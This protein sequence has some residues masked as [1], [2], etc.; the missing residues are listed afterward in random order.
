[1]KT[2]KDAEHVR[3]FCPVLNP[4]PSAGEPKFY[5]KLS[6]KSAKEET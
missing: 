2:E 6:Q 1:M 5:I 4:R 3:I